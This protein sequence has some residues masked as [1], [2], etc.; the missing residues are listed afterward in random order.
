M[1]VIILKKDVTT[2]SGTFENHILDWQ[3]CFPVGVCDT[4]GLDWQDGF[5]EGAVK[6]Q[7]G[8]VGR[9]DVECRRGTSGE[10]G[11]VTHGPAEQLVDDTSRTLSF[12]R[13]I[14][15]AEEKVGGTEV[16]D[17]GID[18][19]GLFQMARCGALQRIDPAGGADQGG[20]HAASTHSGDGDA[21]RVVAVII[22]MG[23]QPADRS[24][25]IVDLSG[26]GCVLAEAVAD[27]GDG[28]TVIA[29]P[30]KRAGEAVAAR[31]RTAVNKDDERWSRVLIFREVK[32][33]PER[34]PAHLGK[35]DIG[36]VRSMAFPKCV[37]ADTKAEREEDKVAKV[38][39]V[40]GHWI[41]KI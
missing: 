14:A 19:A 28:I 13:L 27:A 41:H 20:E 2:V 4:L 29:E 39:F 12:F 3:S 8:R 34:L 38:S 1:G 33:E 37:Q 26:E 17:D 11:V 6:E 9:I 23:A 22:G 21:L 18:P 25:A 30:G 24:F 40:I 10:D 36:M 5:V 7:E 32:V 31:P 35:E 15:G 16:A